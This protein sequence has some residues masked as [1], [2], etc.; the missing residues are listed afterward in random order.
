MAR[1]ACCRNLSMLTYSKSKHEGQHKPTNDRRETAPVAA[2]NEGEG[3][4]ADEEVRKCLNA[5]FPLPHDVYSFLQDTS[6]ERAK[7][8]QEFQD[9]VLSLIRRG[10]FGIDGHDAAELAIADKL[11]KAPLPKEE[12]VTEEALLAR[13]SAEPKP[14]GE[15]VEPS[16]LY[17]AKRARF[18]V[19][20]K[21]GAAMKSGRKAIGPQ[22][23]GKLAERDDIGMVSGQPPGKKGRRNPATK[24]T[25]VESGQPQSQHVDQT[26]GTI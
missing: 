3:P 14:N 11:R 18:E 15:Q 9:A 7:D 22:H 20:L 8:V 23:G 4:P 24:A 21:A 13:P 6:Y 1:R 26:D 10:G 19:D 2:K 25:E 12:G 5:T 16:V 17:E